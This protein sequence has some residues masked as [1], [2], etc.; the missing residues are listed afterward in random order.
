ML[1]NVKQITVWSL[2]APLSPL[3][4]SLAFLLPLEPQYNISTD[5]IKCWFHLNS[6]NIFV[7]IL[8]KIVTHHHDGTCHKERE[9]SFNLDHSQLSISAFFVS[10]TNI[11][12]PLNTASCQHIVLS[13]QKNRIYL[14]SPGNGLK[15]FL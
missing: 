10:N 7:F 2:S 6:L 9:E 8:H 13:R 12:P 5:K 1:L 3:Y 15:I 14:R 11:S 4:I